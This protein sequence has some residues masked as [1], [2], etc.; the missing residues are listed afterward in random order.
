MHRQNATAQLNPI[1][2]IVCFVNYCTL[3]S[4][5]LRLLVLGRL[6]RFDQNTL[7]K[8]FPS[9]ASWSEKKSDSS[10]AKTQKE[11]DL[12]IVTVEWVKLFKFLEFQEQ[13]KIWKDKWLPLKFKQMPC[14][15]PFCFVSLASEISFHHQTNKVCWRIIKWMPF[16][17]ARDC[18]WFIVKMIIRGIQLV[19]IP[20]CLW[21]FAIICPWCR[22]W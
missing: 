15:L 20:S 3:E 7:I 5:I 8:A 21:T 22:L 16:F 12:T 13:T 11:E 2:W 6:L 14:S 9:S 1:M 18:W 10:H 19:M 17:R 4:V